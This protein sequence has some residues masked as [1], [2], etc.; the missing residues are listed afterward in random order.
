MSAKGIS[1]GP[2]STAGKKSKRG[3]T[4]KVALALIRDNSMPENTYVLTA[5]KLSF[6]AVHRVEVYGD[7]KQSGGTKQGGVGKQVVKLDGPFTSITFIKT[8]A[9]AKDRIAISIAKTDTGF[10]VYAEKS[11]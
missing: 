2:E 3:A 6:D 5:E 9:T 4:K 7:T 11:E 1:T 8:G 10:T